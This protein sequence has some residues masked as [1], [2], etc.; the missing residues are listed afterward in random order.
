MCMAKI[1]INYRTG[2]EQGSAVLLKRVLSEYFGS[3]EVFL[4]ST[5]IAPGDDFER[6]LLRRVRG[7]EVLLAVVGSRWLT[8]P[9]A[10]GGRALDYGGDWVRREIAEAL[11]SGVRV[12]P[13][14]VNDAE[15]L[16]NAPL[17]DSIAQL[18]KCQ[19]LRL[20]HQNFEYDLTRIVDTIG[21][22]VPPRHR[23]TPSPP[24]DIA[25][26]ATA[27]GHGRVY[28]AGRDQVVYE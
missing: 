2:D 24:A 9:H 17:P 13:I 14:L 18:A 26:K 6:E 21:A 8:A 25:L 11:T 1:F 16:T 12:V 23:N 4:G 19:Y 7:A 10:S 28:Q 27:Q 20:N 5:M 3:D 15:E 22:H